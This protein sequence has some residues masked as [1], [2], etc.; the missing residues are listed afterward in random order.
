MGTYDPKE[1]KFRR[2]SK[3]YKRGTADILGIYKGRPLAIEVKSEKGRLS[4]HQKLFL[5][6][7]QNNG[8]IAIVA[9]SVEDVVR[10]LGEADARLLV[11]PNSEQAKSS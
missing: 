2:P 11:T 10:Q 3:Y 9:R 6:E 7:F 5:Q 4:I 8:G 1:G